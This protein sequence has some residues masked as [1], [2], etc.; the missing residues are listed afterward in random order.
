MTGQLSYGIVFSQ[1]PKLNL[2]IYSLNVN[3]NS[4]E[5]HHNQL[6]H[7]IWHT[8]FICPELVSDFCNDEKR[9][10]KFVF[11]CPDLGIWYMI[12]FKRYKFIFVSS[13][14]GL[15]VRMLETLCFV[16]LLFLISE[17]KCTIWKWAI[18]VFV[19]WMWIGPKSS[20]LYIYIRFVMDKLSWFVA[21]KYGFSNLACLL[22]VYPL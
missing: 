2:L 9:L 18:F 6:L 4:K 19:I 14:S 8:F 7:C 12:N 17:Y 11:S 3:H 22:L 21:C 16:L 20:G 13:P 15:L 5:K 1:L 10:V